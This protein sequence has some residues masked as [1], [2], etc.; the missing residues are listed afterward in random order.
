MVVHGQPFYAGWGLTEDRD[1][2]LRR[3]RRLTIDEL[4]AATLILYPGYVSLTTGLFTTPE[5]VLDELKA[6]RMRGASR[7]P[8][9]R[10]LWRGMKRMTLQ[11]GSLLR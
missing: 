2:L 8:A 9:W 4:V 1:P 7:L 11:L 6:W 5:R 10:R 3:T